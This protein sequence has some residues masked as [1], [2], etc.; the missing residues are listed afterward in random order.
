[1]ARL[2]ALGLAVLF[3]SVLGI[4]YYYFFRGAAAGAPLVG[5]WLFSACVVTLLQTVRIFP[6]TGY[7][8]MSRIRSRGGGI[9][10]GGSGEP[11]SW[12]ALF[13][14]AGICCVVLDVTL[15][16]LW[17]RVEGLCQCAIVGVLQTLGVEDQTFLT[18]EY[19][20]LGLTTGLIGACLLWLTLW[21]TA[22][23]KKMRH[24]LYTW[25]CDLH[26]CFTTL[27]FGQPTVGIG[28][29][30]PSYLHGSSQSFVA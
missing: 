12:A 26:R 11:T 8:P 9:A 1:M 21:A 3:H 5:A 13:L 28:Y 24:G 23:P 2:L 19:W 7:A 17:R 20:S 29:R 10:D 15:T 22:L 30:P 27:L 16:K 18:C 4:S 25:R 14:E 6:S